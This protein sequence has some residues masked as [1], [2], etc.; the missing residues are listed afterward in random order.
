MAKITLGPL[1]SDIRGKFGD[2]VFSQGKTGSHYVKARQTKTTNP[3]SANQ[4]FQR[5]T[6]ATL[7]KQ[8]QDIGPTLQALWNTYAANGYGKRIVPTG[9]GARS[10][11]H[12][13]TG[14]GGGKGL[15]MFVNQNM[16]RM[17][18]AVLTSPVAG[19][20]I[21]NAYASIE[22]AYST[23]TLTITVH[24][25]I[26]G[27]YCQAWIVGT[28]KLPHRQVGVIAVPTGGP[29][30]TVSFTQV[31]GAKGTPIDLTALIGSEVYIQVEQMDKATGLSSNPSET[32]QVSIA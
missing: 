18:Q 6:F 23:G 26:T 20:V 31:N 28:G 29:P 3:S 9:G 25:M 7:S 1:V 16:I 22:A 11:I 2:M 24:N 19:A 12:G 10:I 14:R 5:T 27:D 32:I 30:A 4:S 13:N 15:F 21:P 8:W 17:G